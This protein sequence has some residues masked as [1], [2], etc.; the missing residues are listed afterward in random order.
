[1]EAPEIGLR[2]AFSFTF[3]GAKGTLVMQGS[4][5]FCSI[6]CGTDV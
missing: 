2:S 3:L 5:D 1:M 6:V 4:C